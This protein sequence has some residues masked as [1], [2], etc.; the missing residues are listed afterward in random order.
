VEKN[1]QGL[2]DFLVVEVEVSLILDV[3]TLKPEKLLVLL[4]PPVS[5]ASFSE[6]IQLLLHRG[7]FRTSRQAISHKYEL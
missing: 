2:G 4:E 5:G 1:E 7:E 6:E 3:F